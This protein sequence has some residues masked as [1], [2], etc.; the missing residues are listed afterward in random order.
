M[1]A[2]ALAL[3]ALAATCRSEPT[4]LQLGAFVVVDLVCKRDDGGQRV[5]IA[6]RCLAT[7]PGEARL[8]VTKL[9]LSFDGAVNAP[10][11]P[12]GWRVRRGFDERSGYWQLEWS[13][14]DAKYGVVAGKRLPGFGGRSSGTGPVR[15][16]GWSYWGIDE[17]GGGFG[18]SSGELIP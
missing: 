6:V 17:S 7:K 12:R 11:A 8:N 10:S 14:D 9:T 4:P 13:V 2:Q 18:S 5:D 3:A 15:L 16:H 1:I